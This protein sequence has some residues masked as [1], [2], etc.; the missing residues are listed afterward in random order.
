MHFINTWKKCQSGKKSY[1]QEK[2]II[3]VWLNTSLASRPIASIK[4]SDLIRIRDEWSKQIQPATVV[5]RFALLSHLYTVAIKDWLWGYLEVNPVQLIRKPSVKNERSRRLYTQ[6]RIVGSNPI[7]CP[8]SEAD[9]IIRETRSDT[10]PTIIILALET[11]MRRSELTG[12]ER[13][14]IDFNQGTIYI[15]E[16]KNGDSRLVPLS[17]IA[18]HALIRY[19]SR[20]NKINKIFQTSPTAV[21]RAF[22]RA[23]RK[24]MQ[25]YIN[26][27][28]KKGQM[29]NTKIFSNLRFHDLRHEATS[30][31]ATVYEMHE[32]AKITGHRDTRMLLRYYHP[33]IQTLNQ[34]LAQSSFGQQQFNLINQ[35]L[36]Q[37]L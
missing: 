25:T 5:R 27:C 16:T 9:W 24:A 20:H 12:I 22:I 8:A 2:S 10:L 28:D 26:L 35:M 13:D 34:K 4:N 14:H 3:K 11:A 30:R 23:R 36:L 31:L 33:D 18:R 1:L 29:P 15:A 37:M 32:L 6:I 21:T 17:P 19:L 7:E